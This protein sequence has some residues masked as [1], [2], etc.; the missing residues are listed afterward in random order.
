MSLYEVLGVKR[1][2]SA[3]ELRKAY[4]KLAMLNHP[5]KNLGDADAA[6]RF[7]RVTL[8]YEVLSDASKR[9]KYDEGEGDDSRIFEGRD[10]AGASDLFDA[11]FGH[12][13]IE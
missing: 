7:L 1:D 6:S 13:F 4:R 10:F 9:A 5:D 2:A 12:G 3:A 11:H 8:A